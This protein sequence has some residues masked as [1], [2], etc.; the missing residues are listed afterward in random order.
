MKF[1]LLLSLLTTPVFAAPA[2]VAHPVKLKSGARFSLHLPARYEIA[3]VVEGLKRPRFFALAP[4]GRLFFTQMHDKTDNS[5]GKV[6]ILD[7]FDARTKRFARQSDY[8]SGLRNPNSVAFWSDPKSGKMWLYLALTDKLV[9]YPFEKGDRTP[10]GAAQTLA[11]FPAY[12]LS[13]KYGGWHLTRTV[14][15]VPETGRVFVAVGSSGNA[16]VEKEAVRA[17]VVTMNADGTNQQ[18][19]ARGLRNAVGMKWQRGALWASNMGADHLGDDAPDETF[20]ALK[21]GA[22]YGW[23]YCYQSNGRV[24]LDPKFRRASGKNGVPL[25]PVAFPAHSSA[26]G[27]DWFGQN[28]P[29]KR[30]QNRWLF[31]LHGS[32]FVRQKRG[33]SLVSATQDGRVEPFLTGFLQR[34]RIH[35]R[36][37]DV[38]NRG[39]GSFFFSDD[40]A[41]VIYLVSPRATSRTRSS[42]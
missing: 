21:S 16:L 13:Y 36:P 10:S 31:A 26:L 3:P 22:D 41:G 8:L 28:T 29:D 37:C 23:P 6:S 5:Q 1:A 32:G 40:Y 19:Y 18:I 15:V 4:D 34:R 39:D 11:K 12:G 14:A 27:F 7:G 20:A 38:F 33:Y 17:A 35:G 2:L 42:E 24:R 25:A 9:R 30:L